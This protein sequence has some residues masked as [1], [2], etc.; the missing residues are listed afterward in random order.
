MRIC[1]ATWYYC[2]SVGSLSACAARQMFSAMSKRPWM[3]P[4][5]VMA[6]AM[7]ATG[8]ANAAGPISED[9][10]D[11]CRAISDDKARLHCFEN[12]TAQPPQAA[13]S[14]AQVAPFDSP[15]IPDIPQDFDLAAGFD[16][17][18]ANRP[19]Q[20]SHCR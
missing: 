19:I 9:A 3:G 16:L 4:I 5:F 10:Y 20:P 18:F 8:M 11:R 17:R 7:N 1:G 6:A 14:P 13:P 12:L 15:K 2:S